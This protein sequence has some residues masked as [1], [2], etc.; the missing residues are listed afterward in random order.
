MS[1][2][3]LPKNNTESHSRIRLPETA[4]A[5]N[6]KEVAEQRYGD[7]SQYMP[8]EKQKYFGQLQALN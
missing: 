8:K 1:Y 3:Y 7:N 4:T 6:A 2:C 5:H